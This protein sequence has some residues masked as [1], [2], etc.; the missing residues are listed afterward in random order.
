MLIGASCLQPFLGG[1]SSTNQI[2]GKIHMGEELLATVDGH[3]V[4]HDPAANTALSVF[5][6][7]TSALTSSSLTSCST[8]RVFFQSVHRLGESTLH[9]W[10]ALVES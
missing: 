1:A 7:P 2:S 9:V 6:L 8:L 3:W 5:S 10:L 4:R